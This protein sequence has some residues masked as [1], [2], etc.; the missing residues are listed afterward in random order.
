MKKISDY[1]PEFRSKYPEADNLHNAHC[2][3][4]SVNDYQIPV[5]S[6]FKYFVSVHFGFQLFCLSYAREYKFFP[7]IERRKIPMALIH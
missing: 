4:F 2:A 1:L 3:L 5:Q 7:V 6:A